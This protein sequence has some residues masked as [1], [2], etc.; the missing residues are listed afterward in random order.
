MAR[1]TINLTDE[2]YAYLLSVSVREPEILTQLREETADLSGSMMQIGPEQGGFMVL[3]VE[4]TGAR[5]ILEIGTYTGYSS[6]AMAMAMPPEGRLVACDVSEEW[7]AVARRYWGRA[8]VA[9]KISLHIRPAL[10]SLDALLADGGAGSFDLAFIDADKENYGNYYDRALE[11]LRP[12]G[13]IAIDNVLWDGRVADPSVSDAD[14]DAIRALNE[15]LHG[16]ERITLC[17][18]PIGDGVTLAR[19]R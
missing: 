10:E 12:G 7:T 8:G 17:M 16:D 5:R 15:R 3:L 1:K 4:L 19:K 18:V 13:L 14:T 9:D 6:T 11:L 2:V